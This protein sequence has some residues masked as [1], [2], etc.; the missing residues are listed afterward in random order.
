[1]IGYGEK[2]KKC[3]TDFHYEQFQKMR[4]KYEQEDGTFAFHVYCPKCKKYSWSDK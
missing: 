1:M 4:I 2:C 3:K